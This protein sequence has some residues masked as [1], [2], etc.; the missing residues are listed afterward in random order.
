MTVSG[1]LRL[2]CVPYFRSSSLMLGAYISIFIILA[3]I[4]FVCAIYSCLGVS[5]TLTNPTNEQILI[6][7]NFVSTSC[8][9]RLGTSS[10]QE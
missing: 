7:S 1:F 3:S 2:N 6:S 10:Y 9:L 8:G 5:Y 4:L